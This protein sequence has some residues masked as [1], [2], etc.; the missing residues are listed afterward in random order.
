M[1]M[2]LWEIVLIALGLSMDA[3]AVAITLGLLLKKPKITEIIIPGIFFGFFQAL[4][5]TIGYFVG[6]YFANKIQAFDHWIAFA[7]LVLIG[8]KMIRESF[9]KKEEYP[10]E[11]AFHFA[12]MLVLAVATS[13]DALAIGITFAIF[14]VNIFRA[15]IIT[16]II[17]FIISIAG[18][19]IG[20]IFGLKFKSKAGFTGGVVLVIIG[21]KIVIEHLFFNGV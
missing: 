2:G 7:L 18:V 21:I 11:N 6:V 15:A 3:F 20:K 12:K 8:G 14:K 19:K 13:I 4:M 5:P 9:S 17:T 16:G 10:A 1:V